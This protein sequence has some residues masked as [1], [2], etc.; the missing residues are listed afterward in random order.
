MT[1]TTQI[2]VDERIEEF[3]ATFQ[4]YLEGKMREGANP[5]VSLDVGRKFTR[6]VKTTWGQASAYCFIDNTT[7]D[8]LKNAGYRT[9]AK[10]ARGS[11]WNDNC[12]VGDGKPADEFG[13][14]LYK[15]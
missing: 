12:D 11:I 4:A 15:R 1:M 13:G 10:G 5:I 2:T 7:G 6:V 14:G 3:R 9:P 8:L